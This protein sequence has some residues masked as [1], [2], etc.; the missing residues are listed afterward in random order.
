MKRV[1]FLAASFV[2]VFVMASM[3][4]A[5]AVPASKIGWIVTSDFG[6]DK[7]GIAKYLTASKALETEMK[8]RALELQTLQTKLNTIADDLAKISAACQNPAIP[9]D[10]KGA[11]AKQEEGQRLKREFEF[12]QKEAQAALDKRRAEVMGPITTNIYQ[13][14]QEYAKVKGYAVVLDIAALGAADQPNPVL[15]LDP[16]ADITK[17]FITWYNARPA[18]TATVTTPK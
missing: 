1:Y 18:T 5:Q 15:V 4:F 9:C 12:K 10:Q 2:F 6:D 3:S 14:L 16:S 8:P 13:A 7:G 17:D 11:A